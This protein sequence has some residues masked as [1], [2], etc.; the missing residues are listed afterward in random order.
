MF[1]IVLLHTPAPQYTLQAETGLEAEI[2]QPMGHQAWR[3]ERERLII[4]IFRH[5]RHGD[6]KF[7]RG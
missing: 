1:P 6:I 7:P 3:G 4:E 2:T 5:H